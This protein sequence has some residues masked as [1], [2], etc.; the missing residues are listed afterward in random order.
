MGEAR[1]TEPQAAAGAYNQREVTAEKGRTGAFK[2]ADVF[3]FG[4]CAIEPENF[5]NQA[6]THLRNKLVKNSFP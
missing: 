5:G 4:E 3:S 6:I 1:K 2:K